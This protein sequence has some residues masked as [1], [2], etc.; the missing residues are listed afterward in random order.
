MLKYP[1]ENNSANNVLDLRC[2]YNLPQKDENVTNLTW[3]YWNIMV[4]NQVK[5][6]AFLTLFEKC[7][8]NKKTKHLWYSK[9]RMQPSL[10]LATARCVFKARLN[11]YEIKA[12]FKKVYDSDISCPFCKIED[13]TFE[14]IFS[15]SSGVLRK[16]SLTENNLLK[17]SHFSCL[18]YLK[19]TGEILLRYKKYR[20]I[21]L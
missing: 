1:A 5:R 6:S 14:H 10:D 21:M 16:N 19:D 8:T 7:L 3:P 20:G 9:L 11:M 2:K 4:K 18:R 17:L 13:E 15:C 12:N